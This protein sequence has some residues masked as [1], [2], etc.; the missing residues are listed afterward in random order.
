MLLKVLSVAFPF[1][2]V[3]PDAV[4]GAEQ[5]L[6]RLDGALAAAGHRS[7]VVA[8]EGSQTAGELFPFTLPA[9]DP[10]S[11]EDR[12][13]CSIGVQA[14]IDR[15]LS[16]HHVDLIH[17][18]GLDLQ[19]Y[20]FPDHLPVVIS[21]HL[22]VPW[23]RPQL[24]TKYAGRA[25][26]CCVSESQ[27]RSLS[28]RVNDSTVIENGVPLPFIDRR[29]PKGDFA[30]AL[31]RVCPEKNAHQA[32]DAG[33]R[34]G[35]RVLLGGEVFPF[36][37]HQQYFRD[38]IEPR[39]QAL[40]R[41]GTQHAFLGRLQQHQKQALLSRAKCLLHPTLAPETSSLVA[42]EAL[43]AGTPVI[44]YRSG[45][46]P[47]IVEDGVTGFLVDN[48]NE[49]ADALGRVHLLSPQACRQAAERR[50]SAERMIERY[51]DLYRTVARRQPVEAL[52]A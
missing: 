13:R 43:A 7:I 50:F 42:M 39:V 11:P 52:C 14:A 44:A 40:P 48:V 10:L 12:S 37:E 4:G 47:E 32:F 36:P 25:Q 33:T 24:W 15:A 6:S 16:A 27:R 49:M 31:G 29:W 35:T 21:L 34:T 51:F 9:S 20:E 8:C 46:L 5:V 2:A 19:A 38:Y 3:C 30:L 23:Y 26:Y 22:P 18:H 41:G 1:A 28:A 17:L 45:A